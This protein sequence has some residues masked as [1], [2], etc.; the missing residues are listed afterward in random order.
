MS[1]EPGHRHM[2]QLL[3]SIPELPFTRDPAYLTAAGN[4]ETVFK[5]GGG[6]TDGAVPG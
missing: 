5:N 4:N 1:Q 3:D 2:S 6:H